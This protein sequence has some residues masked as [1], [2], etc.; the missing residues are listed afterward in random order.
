MSYQEKRS[1]VSI[2]SGIALLAA[3]CLYTIGKYQKG[4][5]APGDLKFWATTILVFI[6]IG[7]VAFIVIQIVFHVILSISIAVSKAVI[8]GNY[9]DKEIEK[10]IKVDMIEDEMDKMIELKSIQ[11]GFTI[12]GIGFIAG[13]VALVLNYSAVVMLNIF[14]ISFSVGSILEGFVKIFYYRRGLNHG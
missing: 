6:G 5:V 9:D 7:I 12:A 10:A 13:L 8:E 14:F 2:L 3:Y 1:I 4:L 11:F